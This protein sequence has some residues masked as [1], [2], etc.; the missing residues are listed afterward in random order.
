MT[1]DVSPT[2]DQPTQATLGNMLRERLEDAPT[3]DLPGE[4]E[5]LLAAL[6][7]ADP[8]RATPDAGQ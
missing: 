6:R 1:R 3:D 5:T 2:L 8:G 4:I 7:A